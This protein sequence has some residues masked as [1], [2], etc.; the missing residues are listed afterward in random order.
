MTRIFLILSITAL[1]A[2][3]VGLI[4]A[5][6]AIFWSENKTKMKAVVYLVIGVLFGVIWFLIRFGVI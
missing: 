4:N 5:G 2:F 1:I 6:R 3:I